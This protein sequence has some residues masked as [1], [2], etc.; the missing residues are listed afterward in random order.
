MPVNAGPEYAAAEQEFQRAKTTEEKLRCLD[1]M[2]ALAPKH[3]SSEG[4]LNEIKQK[5][6]KLK[7]K[8]EKERT[9]KKKGPGAFSIKK[10]GAAQVIMIGMTNSGKSYILNKM[11]GSKI[12][13]A[14]YAFTT[15]NPEQ[16]AMDYEGVKI[17]LV[18]L[19]AIFDGFY[20][21]D[22]G[23]SL[24]AIMR[25]S[26]LI[27]VVLDGL[28]NPL[29]QLKLIENELRKGGV[30]LDGMQKP[31]IYPKKCVVVVNKKFS[32]VN[33]IHKICSF[34]DFKQ[35]VWDK[36]DLVYVQ[37]KM[38]GKKAD[39]PPVCLKKG[40]TVKELAEKV[41]KDFLEKF[42]Y[43]RIWGHSVKH[44]GTTVGLEHVLD[45]KDIV[46]MHLK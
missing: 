2:Y 33:T 31:G 4:L 10:E 12:E 5:I 24:F 8:E 16:G 15:K 7:E 39:W 46:E 19:P 28:D 22:K 37:T 6:S 29:M 40:S 36:L 9:S 23:P 18:E 1:K 42:K 26:D 14:S 45:S 17:Q 34:E 32:Y 20:D 13:V 44:N 27:V 25:E 11:T 3:K 41:H 43:A 38:P 30:V 35:T 21:S